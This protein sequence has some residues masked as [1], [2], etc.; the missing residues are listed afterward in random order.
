M[1]RILA[2]LLA[3]LIFAAPALA[4]DNAVVIT[5][6]SGVT[7]KSKDMGGGVQSMQ[8][9]L[10]DQ[11]GN[12]V[13]GQAISSP[14]P[15]S[16]LGRLVSILNAI[17]AAIPTQSASVQIGGTG[18]FANVGGAQTEVISCAQSAIYDTNTSGS[19]QLVGALGGKIIYVCGYS[20]FSAGG[21]NVNLQ[22]GTGSNCG[23]GTT[24][25]TPAYQLTAQTGLVD[26]SPYYR[27]LATTASQ[28]LCLNT[29]AGVAV[30]AIVYYTQF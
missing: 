17:N 15:N 6:G 13:L 7:M 4:A 28:Q 14:A 19:T 24:K 2:L 18:M 26:G 9:N 27:G 16:M 22:Y 1:K 8:P 20:L 25:I 3:A 29:S 21:V 12:E 10:L 30:Q 5:P 23:T 11:A